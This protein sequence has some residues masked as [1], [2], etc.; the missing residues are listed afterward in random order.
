MDTLCIGT[1]EVFSKM[2]GI[3]LALGPYGGGARLV[4]ALMGGH[5][6]SGTMAP[7]AW[8]AAI[9]AGAIKALAVTST[10]RVARLPDIPTVAESGVP[11]FESNGSF[12]IVAPAGTPADVIATLNAAF[13]KVLNDPEIVR[14][15]RDLG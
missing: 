10:K 1:A 5:I 8:M 13:V 2:V 6:S 9:E 11:D 15:I 12:G 4:T 14:R 3:G 7:P